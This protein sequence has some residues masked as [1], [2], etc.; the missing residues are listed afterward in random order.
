MCNLAIL[1]RANC[2]QRVKAGNVNNV[3]E[4]IVHGAI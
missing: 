3:Y 4:S 2:E 1:M